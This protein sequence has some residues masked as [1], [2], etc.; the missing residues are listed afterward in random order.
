[1]IFIAET[2]VLFY[3]FIDKYILNPIIM[4]SIYIYILI[5]MIEMFYEL[6]KKLDSLTKSYIKK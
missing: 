6:L 3:F 1:M 5:Y 4:Y 2:D